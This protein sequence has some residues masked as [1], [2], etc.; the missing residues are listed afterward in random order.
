MKRP[1][2]MAIVAIGTITAAVLALALVA[3]ALGG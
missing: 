2:E 3:G 1:L